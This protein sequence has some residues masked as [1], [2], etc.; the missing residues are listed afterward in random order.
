[1]M[2]R[3]ARKQKHLFKA[4]HNLEIYTSDTTMESHYGKD[5]PKNQ[6]WNPPTDAFV[7]PLVQ[8]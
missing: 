5:H 1:M 4:G 7:F 3:V 6:G 8:Y 2:E